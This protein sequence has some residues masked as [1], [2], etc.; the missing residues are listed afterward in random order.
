[1][2][3]PST[4]ATLKAIGPD[5]SKEEDLWAFIS[6]NINLCLRLSLGHSS[7]FQPLSLSETGESVMAK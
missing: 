4:L 3:H 7:P 5:R 2:L 6:D 1:V